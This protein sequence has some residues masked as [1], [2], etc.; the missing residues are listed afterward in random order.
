MD[1]TEYIALR[2]K[3]VVMDTRTIFVMA[4]VMGENAVISWDKCCNERGQML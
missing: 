1:Q 4:F 3:N 2:G